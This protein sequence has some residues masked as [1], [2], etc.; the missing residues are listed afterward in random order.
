MIVGL[1]GCGTVGKSVL[2]I[3]SKKEDIKIKRILVRTLRDDHRMTTDFMD[4]LHDQEID[5]IIEVMGGLHPAYEYI[6][7]SL[8]AKKNVVTANKAV[9]A[10]YFEELNQLAHDNNVSFMIE[11]CVGGGIP[12]IRELKRVSRF[13]EITSISGIFN[14]TTNYILSNMHAY[15]AD[16]DVMIK[17][18]QNKGYAES[19][20]SADLEGYDIVNKLA[21]SADVAF[22]TFLNPSS[23]PVFGISTIKKEDIAYFKSK[24]WTCKLMAFAQKYQ[25]SISAFCMPTLIKDDISSQINANLNLATAT[26]QFLGT[27]Q[28]IGQGAGGDPTA[29]A[30]ISDCYDIMTKINHFDIHHSYPLNLSMTSFPFYIRLEKSVFHEELGISYEYDEKYVYI[31]TAKMTIIE[32]FKIIDRYRCND[33]FAALIWR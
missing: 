23:I 27:I 11:A 20:P 12:W 15:D 26:S 30:V 14:G 1:L 4:I 13:D 6:S 31:Q 19:D 8:K 17:D 25:N 22:Q 33:F 32:I 24:G 16:F 10:V 28:L 9:A 29:S 2:Q 18:A 3:A 7:M 5:T 21:L